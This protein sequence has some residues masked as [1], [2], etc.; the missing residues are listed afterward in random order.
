MHMYIIH[1][2]MTLL[3]LYAL[4]KI[5]RNKTETNFPSHPEKLSLTDHTLLTP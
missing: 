4:L 2:N 3:R 5:Y 1:L